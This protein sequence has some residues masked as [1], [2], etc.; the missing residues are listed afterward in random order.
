METQTLVIVLLTVV[1]AFAPPCL[2]ALVKYTEIP[3]RYIVLGVFGMSVVLGLL[4]VMITL[5]PSS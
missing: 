1:A 4:L 3:I 2:G 5:S